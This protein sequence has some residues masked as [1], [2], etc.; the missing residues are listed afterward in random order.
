M[1]HSRLAFLV[2]PDRA[3]WNGV[4]RNP[5]ISGIFQV[6]RAWRV[7]AYIYGVPS[8]S[9]ADGVGS[10]REEELPGQPCV[11][12]IVMFSLFNKV[13]E[14]NYKHLN[15]FILTVFNQPSYQ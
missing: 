3:P 5:V 11:Q 7:Q 13:Y 9:R 12:S 6:A 2:A 1:H 14:D 8:R 10:F 15:E 4:S